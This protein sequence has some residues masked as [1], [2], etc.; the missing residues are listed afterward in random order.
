VDTDLKLNLVL[1][2]NIYHPSEPLASPILS[3]S[4]NNPINKKENSHPHVCPREKRPNSN[5]EK[6]VGPSFRGVV[7]Q[8]YFGAVPPLRIVHTSFPVHGSS[9]F[10]RPVWD[11]VSQR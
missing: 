9:L 5:R 6:E 7:G 4:L 10:K 8:A 2:T 11:A 1:A 3:Y